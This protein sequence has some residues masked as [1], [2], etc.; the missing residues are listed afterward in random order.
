MM[1][2]PKM[3][4]KRVWRSLVEYG[5]GPLLIL[6]AQGKSIEELKLKNE[7][8]KADNDGSEVNAGALFSIF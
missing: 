3:Q 7:W 5:Q 8:N 2:F 4:G 1:F 6:D